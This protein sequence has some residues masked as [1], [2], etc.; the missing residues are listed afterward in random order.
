MP[1]SIT[2]ITDN[3]SIAESSPEL[4]YIE[5]K[6]NIRDSSTSKMRNTITKRKYRVVKGERR[7]AI[8]S[9]PHSNGD[10]FSLEVTPALIFPSSK[11]IKDR[12]RGTIVA[13]IIKPIL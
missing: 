3:G 2:T 9:K 8:G 13:T 5:I 11:I 6:G 12:I 10:T 7:P 1:A 4:T